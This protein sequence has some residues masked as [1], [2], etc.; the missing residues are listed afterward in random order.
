M[1]IP[2]TFVDKLLNLQQG[3]HKVKKVKIKKGVCVCV[4]NQMAQWI[5]LRIIGWWSGDGGPRMRNHCGW[6]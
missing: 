1:E 6:L 2:S 3:Q 5:I 4:W